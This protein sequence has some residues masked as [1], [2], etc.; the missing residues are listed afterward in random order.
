MRLAGSTRVQ[1][2]IALSEERTGDTRAVV[3]VPAGSHAE[4]LVAAPLAALVDAPVL[5]TG[6]AGLDSDV[7]AEVRR[8]EATSA[9]LVGSTA[10]LAPQTEQDLSAAGITAMA[11]LAA[12][13]A[14]AL[15]AAVAREI[16][17]Y[18]NMT[19]FP[20]V[21]LALGE[22]PDPSRAWPDALSA[23][24]LAA[25]LRV[26]ILL[27]RGGELPDTVATVLDELQPAQVQVIGGTA[28][29]TDAVASAAAQAAGGAH[30]ERLSGK[31]RYGTSVA[32]AQAGVA[33]GLTGSIVWLATGRNFPDALAAGP[34]AARAGSPLLLVDGQT[35]GGAP[36]SEA[37]LKSEAGRLEALTVVGGPSAVSSDVAHALARQV[38]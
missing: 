16:L 36:E 21:L 17:S 13:D 2:A 18:P 37:W 8:L 34:A 28:A 14:F 31:T 9:Y 12:P 24:A 23:T 3:I 29:V 27:T 26:P 7:A 25:R 11:R 19:K 4:A 30:V 22:A 5:L 20:S 15:S 35:A 10:Q 33:A 6:Q 38:Q 32:V 1:T